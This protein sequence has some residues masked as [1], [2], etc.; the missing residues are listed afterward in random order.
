M[1]IY[2][3]P[4][5]TEKY[6]EDKHKVRYKDANQFFCNEAHTPS[7]RQ[8]TLPVFHAERNALQEENVV[9]YTC[10]YSAQRALQL[11]LT[12]HDGTCNLVWI[13]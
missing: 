10:T 3:E 13:R 7:R 11:T 9:H 6:Y 5:N 2:R 8:R 12:L 1:E 4:T